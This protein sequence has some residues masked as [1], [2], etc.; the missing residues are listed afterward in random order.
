MYEQHL[1]T[2]GLTKNQ[3]LIYEALIKNGRLSGGD[4]AYKAGISRP[5]TYKVLDELVDM[6]LV[7]KDEKSAKTA[8]F[9]PKHPS[10]LLDIAEK[11]KRQAETAEQTLSAILGQISSDFNLIAGR[12]NVR[13]FEGTDG[14]K[15]V[16]EDSLATKD[17]ILSYTDIETIQK[18][19]AEVSAEY[20]R[21]REGRG[22][23]KRRI[24]VDTPFARAFVGRDGKIPE[25]IRFIKHDAP[26]FQT[27]MQIYDDTVSY[28]TLDKNRMIG[29]IIEDAHIA[30]MHKY[31][32]EYAWNT[33]G[34]KAVD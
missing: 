18:Y 2:A 33:A 28:I 22:I 29:V 19:F 17:E 6:G 24:I 4:T 7:E 15:K 8:R 30:K 12:P 27:V 13:F 5:L 21:A 23:K 32:F 14:L 20:V 25:D 16:L 31:L 10:I 1:T 26:P 11:K 9:V 3:A 34:L